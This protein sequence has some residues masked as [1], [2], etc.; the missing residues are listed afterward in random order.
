MANLPALKLPKKLENPLWLYRGDIQE[1][2]QTGTAYAFF[3]RFNNDQHE[4][5]CFSDLDPAGIQIALT[6]YA[7]YWLSP[8]DSA[9]I[10]FSGAKDVEKEWYK[11]N[12][13]VQYLK[14]VKNLP[15][16]CQ[17]AFELM[18]NNRKTLKQEHMLA[19]QI[20]LGLYKL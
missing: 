7:Q 2:Q 20:P 17:M 14:N 18:L 10:E 8:N 1:K 3:K 16:K 19:H 12:A 6:C 4:L 5:I 11:Q 9:V 15:D 13:A